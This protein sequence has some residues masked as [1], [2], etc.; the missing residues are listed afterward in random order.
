ME[1]RWL[2]DAL[3][4]MTLIYR[5]IAADDPRAAGGGAARRLTLPPAQVAL[6]C[7]FEN[8]SSAG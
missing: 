4:D 7:P 2:E 8:R 5:H 3:A 6:G 1:I